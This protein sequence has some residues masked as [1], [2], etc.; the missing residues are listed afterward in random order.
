MTNSHEN[1]KIKKIS[2]KKEFPFLN[3]IRSLHH[4]STNRL[5]YRVCVCVIFAIHP[6]DIPRQ[7]SLSLPQLNEQLLYYT[8]CT[9]VLLYTVGCWPWLICTVGLGEKKE[10][11][12]F[13]RSRL[14]GICIQR[15]IIIIINILLTGNER[16]GPCQGLP[17][18]PAQFLFSLERETQLTHR[19]TA[20][21]RR[22]PLIQRVGV[23][24]HTS[25]HQHPLPS[26]RIRTGS[27]SEPY[28][29]VYVIDSLI[30]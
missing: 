22:R 18:G 27:A 14:T 21:R 13:V 2:Q 8:C 25:R 7:R 20:S 1:K 28:L 10:N 11:N 15:W 17:A 12:W 3:V 16:E 29:D 9:D 19:L 6:R 26:H 23:R 4:L 24:Q 30:L 5:V